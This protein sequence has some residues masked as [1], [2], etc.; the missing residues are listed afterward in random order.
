MKFRWSGL[1][2]SLDF[3]LEDH[4]IILMRP[5]V[6]PPFSWVG[7][8]PFAYLAVDLLRPA[9]IV[10]L[11]THSG[12]SYLAM[13]QAVRALNL[14]T[15]CFAIDTW[16]GDS[17]AT[18]YGEQVFQALRAR[19]DPR[20]GDFSRLIRGRFDDALEHFD[21]QSIDLLHIDGLHTYEAV[22]HDFETWLPKLSGRAV[23]LLHD[24]TT[25]GRGFGVHAFFDELTQRYSCF[26]F[27]H[28]HGLGIVAVGANIPEPFVAF[29]RRAQSSP[30]EF[31][32]FFAA[33][34]AC[35]IDEHGQPQG[36]IGESQPVVCHLYYRRADEPYDDARKVSFEVNALE[37]TL[38][39]QFQLPRGVL[40]DYLRI[41]PADH[42]GIYGLQQVCLRQ[43]GDVHAKPLKRLG[44]R[45]GHVEGELL[46]RIGMQSVYFASFGDDPYVEFEVG[47]AMA[48]F[49]EDETLEVVARIDYE[50]V[51]AEPSVRRLIERHAVTDIH[52]RA[53]AKVDVQNLARD[54]SRQFAEVSKQL[55]AISAQFIEM[56]ARL[57]QIEFTIRRSIWQRIRSWLRRGWG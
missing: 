1:P 23:V 3:R 38:D 10:E 5:S 53:R 24:T 16:Q 9:T 46:Q 30:S 55:A 48:G 13:C 2:M 15:R 21:D 35:L 4:P 19:H 47:S 39:V 50:I 7:Y 36:G 45:L 52:E 31:R 22:K 54:M 26:G 8:I 25:E 37:G 6:S 41:D 28:S 57:N 27:S 29:M 44:D 49:S 12:N 34:A 40:P 18:H 17:H 14:S 42:P 33:Q 11:G 20:Y 51:L 32:A 43:G 56:N